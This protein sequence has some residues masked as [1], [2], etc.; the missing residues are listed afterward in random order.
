MKTYCTTFAALFFLSLAALQAAGDETLF[1]PWRHRDVGAVEVAGSASADN[2]V[3]TVK[4]TLDTWGTNDGFHFVWQP[5]HG[6]GEIVARVT[7]VENTLPH[8]KGGIMI[9][10]SL[11]PGAKHAQACITATDGAQFLVRSTANEKT[12]AFP[13]PGDKGKF[14]YWI[15]LVRA[16]D[17]FTGYASAD[18]QQWKVIGST[19]ISMQ[20]EV[21]A[22]ITASSHVKTKL[23]TATF[24]NVR[25]SAAR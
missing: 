3:F 12:T 14:P 5:L 1:G 22:G 19:N 4:G 25:V 24:D 23:C 7:S 18:G 13:L 20:A 6:N 8:A 21:F 9:R 17:R 2:G 10:D 11:A 15:R 16:G